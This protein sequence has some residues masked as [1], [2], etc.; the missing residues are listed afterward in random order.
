M[1]AWQDTLVR[2]AITMAAVAVL[3]GITGF[4]VVDRESPMLSRIRGAVVGLLLL[5]LLAGVAAMLGFI[6]K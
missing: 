1:E 6:W 2:V 5:A 3:I 4:V